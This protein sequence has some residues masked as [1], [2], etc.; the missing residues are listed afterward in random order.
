MN[1]IFKCE[2][3][4]STLISGL[5]GQ[6]LYTLAS[7]RYI[8]EI[9]RMV[10]LMAMEKTI[11]PTAVFFRAALLTV[12]RMASVDLLCQME[13]IIKDKS[14]LVEPMDSE[15]T[16]LIIHRIKEISRTMLDMAKVNKKDK[17]IIIQ[18]STNTEKR[19]Q[20]YIN[21]MAMYIKENSLMDYSTEKVN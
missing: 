18:D 4:K 15:H 7:G 20:V 17:A 8:C 9:F 3:I 6:E 12:F 10:C 5:E 13:I 16:K 21:I 1:R 19:N 11:T 2:E 14:S